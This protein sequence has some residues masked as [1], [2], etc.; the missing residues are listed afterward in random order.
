MSD[1]IHATRARLRRIGQRLG[2]LPATAVIVLLI[3]PV[4]I[5]Y[6]GLEYVIAPLAMIAMQALALHELLRGYRHRVLASLLATVV[7]FPLALVVF[8]LL[9][10][11]SG[12]ESFGDL[13]EA[14]SPWA[15]AAAVLGMTVIGGLVVIGFPLG[16]GVGLAGIRRPTRWLLVLISS[17]V[18]VGFFVLVAYDIQTD[19]APAEDALQAWMVQ[20]IIAVVFVPL[21]AL[22]SLGS[23]LGY[24]AG[25]LLADRMRPGFDALLH[26]A[27]YLEPLLWPSVGFFI[28]YLAIAVIFAGYYA[29]LDLLN[30]Q[31]YQ[32]E[33][34][35][36]TATMGD[37]LYFSLMTMLTLDNGKIQPLAREAKALVATQALIATGWMLIFF[38]AVTAYV[39]RFW[40][41]IDHEEFE[42]TTSSEGEAEERLVRL[43]ALLASEQ[44]RA[45]ARHRELLE[46]L[47]AAEARRAGRL[48]AG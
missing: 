43:E 17:L 13:I 15:V 16:F 9:T 48:G 21:A 3:G 11:A 14:A 39:Q 2:A 8:S 20:L 4:W 18:V 30:D 29:T 33:P 19:P 5:G 10:A 1:L 47:R 28:G 46:Q 42:Q 6:N 34:D 40:S 37:F 27:R 44:E 32:V 24:R 25:W 36:A 22:T 31:A 12:G 35:G 26:A 23:I 7:T 38:A 45:S 41:R